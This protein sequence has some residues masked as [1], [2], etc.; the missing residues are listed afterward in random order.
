MIVKAISQSF[1]ELLFKIIR[2]WIC[3]N[4]THHKKYFENLKILLIILI[5]RLFIPDKWYEIEPNNFRISQ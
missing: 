4:T 3:L 2:T 5:I 1:E